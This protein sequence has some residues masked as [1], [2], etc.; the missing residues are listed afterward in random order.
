MTLTVIA[1]I[2]TRGL[3]T[4]SSTFKR[5]HH[6]VPYTFHQGTLKELF[7]NGATFYARLTPEDITADDWVFV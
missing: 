6:V 7:T 5:P 4:G 1:S 2:T 3:L